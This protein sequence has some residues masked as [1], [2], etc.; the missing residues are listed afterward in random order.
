MLCS[1]IRPAVRNHV[2]PT[3]LIPILLILASTASAELRQGLVSYWPFDSVSAETTGDVI[4][5]N[6][7][8][9]YKMSKANL[10]V[11]KFGKALSFDGQTQLL[12]INYLTHKQLPIHLVESYSVSLWVKGPPNQTNRILFAEGNTGD[13]YPLFIIGTQRNGENASACIFVR[14]KKEPLIDN[15]SSEGVVFDRSWH[16]IAWVD[17]NGKCRLYI[18]GV[19]DVAHYEYQREKVYLNNLSIGALL[20]SPP[21][22]FFEGELDDIAIWNR[23]LSEDEI[24]KLA[25][26]SVSQLIQ[27][28]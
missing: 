17:E 27:Q 28:K 25:T 5:G 10:V 9:L 15:I 21:V 26:Q 3:K 11:G 6:D 4:S 18:D 23:A 13:R 12:S 14:G 2:S 8:F 1:G 20:R 7:L 19:K 24:R 22:Y 16:H